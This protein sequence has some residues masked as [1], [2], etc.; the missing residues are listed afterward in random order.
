MP[1]ENFQILSHVAELTK[2]GIRVLIQPSEK[3][4]FK[5]KIFFDPTK[6]FFLWDQEYVN[7]G[8]ELAEDL[9]PASFIV[10]VK[11]V[12]PELLVADRSYL[13]FSHVIKAQ[14]YD[15]PLLDAILQKNIRKIISLSLA[16]T[17]SVLRIIWLWKNNVNSNVLF[18][19]FKCC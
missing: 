13:F 9:S 18:F 7:A 19:L 14:P 6:N 2:K 16:L 11:E 8:A 15:M 10:G 5:G 4:I 17:K 12:P 3:R 1:F